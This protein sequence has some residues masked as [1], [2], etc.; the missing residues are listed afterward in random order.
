MVVINLKDVLDRECKTKY[1]LA[2][3]TGMKERN[4][5]NIMLGLT[6][7]ISFDTLEKFCFYLHCTPNDL[8]TFVFD[9]K[10][11]DENPVI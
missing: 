4:I 9:K 10:F 8:I 7:S 1:W 5:D 6:D 11:R 2:K 3:Q